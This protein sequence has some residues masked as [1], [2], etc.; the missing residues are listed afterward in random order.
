MEGVWT[1]ESGGFGYE[2]PF[3]QDFFW[4]LGNNDSFPVLTKVKYYTLKSIFTQ[5]IQNKAREIIMIITYYII[6]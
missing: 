2:F 1:L 4:N 5:Y 3:D 6:S